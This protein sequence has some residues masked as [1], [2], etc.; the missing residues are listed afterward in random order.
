MT[1]GT[2][3]GCSRGSSPAYTRG[4]MTPGSG[5]PTVTG[6]AALLDLR[7]LRWP[8]V[9]G[10]G[11]LTFFQVAGTIG[12]S[13]NGTGDRALDGFGL[14]IAAAGPLSLI[15]LARWPRQVMWFV[16]AITSIY[17]VAGLTTSR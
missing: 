13:H 4:P 8:V 1:S 10:A 11:A 9:A 14:A 16:A 5:S 12:A 17:L 3:S 6:V 15:V 7:G 2:R